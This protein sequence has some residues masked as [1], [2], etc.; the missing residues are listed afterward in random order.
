MNLRLLST[1]CVLGA[2][3][4]VAAVTDR[5]LPVAAITSGNSNRLEIQPAE[6]LSADLPASISVPS[7]SKIAFNTAELP[8]KVAELKS[9]LQSLHLI[10]VRSFVSMPQFGANRARLYTPTYSAM[11]FPVQ[12]L[13]EL[14][15][16][17]GDWRAEPYLRVRDTGRKDAIEG[18]EAWS[19]LYAMHGITSRGLVYRQTDL[20][21][22]WKDRRSNDTDET[23]VVGLPTESGRID[24]DE[25]YLRLDAA[26][27]LVP[28]DRL[29]GLHY[30][31]LISILEHDPPVAYVMNPPDMFQR[32]VQVTTRFLEHDEQFALQRLSAGEDLVITWNEDQGQA[33]LVGAIRAEEHCL[34]CHENMSRNDLL[35]AFTYRFEETKVDR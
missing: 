23:F 2:I 34:K 35:G 31:Q 7:S 12:H 27:P 22:G 11:K 16:V 4:I 29:W 5:R 13:P 33:N 6:T 9:A 8:D 3:C 18:Y 25:G 32:E 1:M 19:W 17:R 10:A 30:M 20:R 14:F 15:E 24:L 28:S 21:L 26:L